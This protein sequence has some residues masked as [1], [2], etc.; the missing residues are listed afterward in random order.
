MASKNPQYV[1]I[2]ALFDAC[3]LNTENTR[4]ICGDDEPIYLPANVHCTEHGTS[5]QHR[6]LFAHGFV[7]SALHEI[8]HWCIA[9]A[10]RRLLTDFGYWYE[11]DGRNCSSQA[12]FAAV[13]ARPQAIEWVLSKSC[14]KTFH[15]SLDNLE[16][17]LNDFD[18]FKEAILAQIQLLK[19]T[20]LPTRSAQF[21]QVLSE[22]YAT[23]INWQAWHFNRDELN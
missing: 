5:L 4:L 1:D 22:F 16:L 20:G 23:G 15:V 3:F 9:G 21:Q 6:I 10:K 8:S 14:G 7:S 11:P 2:I 19:T 12:E 18:E 17:D 13:E